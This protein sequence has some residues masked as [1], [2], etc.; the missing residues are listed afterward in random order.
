MKA[1]ELASRRMEVITA[2]LSMA[3]GAL[4]RGHA[5]LDK[6]RDDVAAAL[7]EARQISGAGRIEEDTA[8]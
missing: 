4:R 1:L 6:C 2:D 5:V 8:G 7:S 3:E